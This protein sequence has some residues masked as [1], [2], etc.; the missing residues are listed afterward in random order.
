MPSTTTT[1]H[2]KKMQLHK[3]GMTWSVAATYIGVNQQSPA[4]VKKLHQTRYRYVPCTAAPHL[5]KP[6]PTGRGR[7]RGRGPAPQMERQRE[8]QGTGVLE[9]QSILMQLF[10]WD[11]PS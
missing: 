11:S 10:T 2:C 7:G 3:F 9:L 4:G 5:A 8:Q 1:S 6:E